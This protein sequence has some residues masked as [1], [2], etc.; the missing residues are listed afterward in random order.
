M[1]QSLARVLVHI[2][3]STK[4]RFPFLSDNDLRNEMHA[5]LGGTYNKLDCPVVT[6]GGTAGH[7]HILC[8]FTRKLSI[9][10]VLGESK[11]ESSK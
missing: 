1:P 10:E 6:V 8:R 9:A 5:Y 7:I 3:F 2:V 4:N 11:R